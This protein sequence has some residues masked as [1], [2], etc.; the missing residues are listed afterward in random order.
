MD[1]VMQN[2]QLS[3]PQVDVSF[4]RSLARRMGWEI[5]KGKKASVCHLDKAIASSKRDPLFETN[6]IDELMNALSE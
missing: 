1:T 6:D 5:A 2:I 3:V 4:L